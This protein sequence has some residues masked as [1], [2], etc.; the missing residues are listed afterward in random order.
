MTPETMAASA[1]SDAELVS[2]S[3]TVSR[4]AFGELVERYQSLVCSLAYS[5]TGDLSQS[6]DLAQ[7]PFLTAWKQLGTLRES[8]KLRSWLCGIARNLIH[9]SL[10]KQGR[11]PSHAADTLDAVQDLRATSPLPHDQT[12]SVGGFAVG[13]VALGGG[14][15]GVLSFAGLALGVW[16]V[17][18]AALGYEAFGG[19]AMGWQGAMGGMAVAHDFALGEAAFAQHANDPAAQAFMQHS[20]FFTHAAAAMRYAVLLIWL[21]MLLV[22]WQGLRGRR[23]RARTTETP[24]DSQ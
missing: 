22:A 20:V 6:E 24:R 23:K 15:L 21:P 11:E 12:I 18:G 7:E 17:G 2:R 14:T 4:D 19:G 9:H 13:Q 5:A 8:G 3:L 1:D 16:A 10:R